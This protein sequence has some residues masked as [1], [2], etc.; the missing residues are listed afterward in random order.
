[1]NTVAE[2]TNRKTHIENIN[3]KFSVS[4]ED[5]YRLIGILIYMS[6]YRTDIQVWEVTGAQTLLHQYKKTCHRKN[7]C[8]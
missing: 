3:T 2:E 5:M 6:V 8:K 4:N 7:S 1:M